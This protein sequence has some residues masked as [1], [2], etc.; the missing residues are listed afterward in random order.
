MKT[1]Y[2]SASTKTSITAFIAETIIKKAKYTRPMKI[3]THWRNIGAN[4]RATNQLMMKG[5]IKIPIRSNIS[6]K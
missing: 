1:E 3:N 4:P 5:S 2:Q 6:L